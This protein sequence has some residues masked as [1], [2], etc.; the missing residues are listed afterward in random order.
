[1]ADDSKILA[2]LA[3]GLGIL[4]TAI[5]ALI[6]W[7]IK[8]DDDPFIDHHGKQAMNFQITVFIA[9][10]VSSLLTIV[11]IG[12]LLM[13]IVGII[14]LVLT[15]IAIIKTVDGEEYEYPKWAAIR[16]FK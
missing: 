7:L 14:F 11:L 9:M 8:K 12:L 2:A 5:P 3:H 15:I 4:V 13:P 1:M 6:I 10:L 16:F